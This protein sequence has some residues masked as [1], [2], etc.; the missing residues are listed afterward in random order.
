MNQRS[1]VV[2]SVGA[3]VDGRV[4]LNRE[5]V[6]MDEPTGSICGSLAPPSANT[7]QSS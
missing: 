3:T 4:A 5:Q 6:L 7:S 1:K 2:V